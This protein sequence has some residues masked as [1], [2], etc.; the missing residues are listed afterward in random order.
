MTTR[1]IKPTIAAINSNIFARTSSISILLSGGGCYN[2]NS[3][4]SKNGDHQWIQFRCF[5]SRK[6]RKRAKAKDPFKVLQVK[7]KAMYKDVKTKFLKIAMHNHPDLHS[8]S[9]LSE[10]DKDT[11]RNTFIDARI[12]FEL[13]AED[14][15]GMVV[16][17]AEKIDDEESNFDSWFHNETG[18][19]NPFD[20]DLDPQTMKEIAETVEKMGGDQGLDRD[21]GMWTL[22][23]MVTSTVK[24]GGSISS[25]LRLESGD[26]K[27]SKGA[28]GELGRRKR[29][30]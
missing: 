29:K 14:T 1:T 21:G 6:I 22:A 16:L 27:K 19:K 7:E 18:L 3:A 24:A 13:L 23:R 8:S 2:Q 30:Y 15:D 26:I 9:D 10:T 20:V 25:I 28:A 17:K 11:M 12:A 5:D 4:C